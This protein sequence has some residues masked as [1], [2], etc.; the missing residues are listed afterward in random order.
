M[1]E[2]IWLTLTALRYDR[3]SGR[4]IALAEAKDECLRFRLWSG[5]DMLRNL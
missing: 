2:P 1:P 3:T 5:S 4:C